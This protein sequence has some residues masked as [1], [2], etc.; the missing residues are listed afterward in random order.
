MIIRGLGGLSKKVGG[1]SKIMGG[2]SKRVGGHSKS[3]KGA[4]APRQSGRHVADDVGVG[5]GR[6]PDAQGPAVLD[7]GRGGGALAVH[8]EKKGIGGKEVCGWS[9]SFASWLTFSCVALV[10]V[11][12]CCSTIAMPSL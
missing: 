8:R 6:R 3:H 12:H 2:R 11:T 7:G 5:G 1:R 10:P 9:F 4:A